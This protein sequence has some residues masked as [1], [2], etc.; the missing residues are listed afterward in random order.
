M[1]LPI[2][3]F[4][5]LGTIA[6]GAYL[7]NPFNKYT[8]VRRPYIAKM[9][10]GVIQA[11][12]ENNKL[13]INQNPLYSGFA[14]AKNVIHILNSRWHRS[15][16]SGSTTVKEIM[17]DIYKLR[18]NP[19]KLLLTSGDHFSALF[20]RN[21]G[22]FYYPTLDP[23]IPASEERWHDRQ[24]VYIQT[25]AYALGVFAKQ[26]RLTTT[27]VPTGRYA[28]TCVNFHAYPSD[29]MYGMLYALAALLGK[30]SAQPARYASSIHELDSI[31]AAEI[32][33]ATYGNSLSAHY[34]N[35]RKKAFDESTGLV[36]L[37]ALMSGAKDIT[38]RQSSFYDNVVFWKTTQ[39]AMTLGLIPEDKTFLSELKKRILKTFWLEE[40]GYFLE[41]LSEEGL[42]GKY[43]SSDWMLVLATGFLTPTKKSE[44]EYFVRSV[45]Y[46]RKMKIDSPFPVKYQ[47]ET[48]AHRQ[49]FFVRLAVAVYGGDA[50]WSFWGMEYM[51]ILMMLSQETGDADYL[52]ICDKHIKSYK[53]NMIKNRGFPEVYDKSGNLLET[54]FYRS[55]RQTGWVVGFDQV[56]AMRQSLNDTK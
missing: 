40:E 48:R 55:I 30:E 37:S 38:K 13:Q 42:T 19:H 12:D 15:P 3:I 26:A 36:R 18:F 1:L 17:D 24:I 4:A 51:K 5:V 6:I 53:Q 2:S 46:I 50:I 22:V 34:R 32:L 21:L 29:T 54:P 33:L 25:L 43:Y 20:V 14:V 11:I 9:K 7:T 8:I 49:F 39:L 16:A 52:A 27:I 41:D 31:P 56:L 28:A 23:A 45:D 10:D 35:Y 47:H 44:R